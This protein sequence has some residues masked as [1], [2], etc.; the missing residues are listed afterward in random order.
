MDDIIIIYPLPH[1]KQ[2][3][4]VGKRRKALYI[5]VISKQLP[6]NGKGIIE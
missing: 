1:K 2:R 4:V 3:I 5:E 6:L